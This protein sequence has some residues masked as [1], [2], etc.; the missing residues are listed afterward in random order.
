[1]P[2]FYDKPAVF[3]N[4]NVEDVARLNK[5][6]FYLVKNEINQFATWNE[7]D[8]LYGK[9]N[10]QSNQ[11]DTMKGSLFRRATSSTLPF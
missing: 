11:G 9:I 8:Q 3:Q 5:L 1:M 4:G 2:S 10:W 7:F 6:P